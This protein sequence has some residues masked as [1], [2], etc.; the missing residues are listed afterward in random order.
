MNYI[1]NKSIFIILLFSVCSLFSQ[2]QNVIISG[3]TG[4]GG[5]TLTTND[6]TPKTTTSNSN[7]DYSIIVDTDGLWNGNIT[8]S[9]DGYTF[10][11]TQRSY[12]ET[13]G[14]T[15]QNYSAKLNNYSITGN[16]GTGGVT[17][18]WFEGRDQ[19]TVT[20]KSDGTYNVTV[21]HGWSGTIT[22][23][24]TGFTFN[25]VNKSYTNVTANQSNQNYIAFQIFIISGNTGTGNVL[26]S[27]TDGTQ[28]TTI[29][30][31]SGNYSISI[32]S[33]WNGT[34]VPSKDG[35]TFD[36]TSK[37][38]VEVG[39]DIDN[40][41]YA[42]TINKY[43]ITAVANPEVGGTID[44]LKPGGEYNH[45]ETVLITANSNTGFQ[46]VNWTLDGNEVSTDS[47]LSFVATGS[48]NYVANFELVKLNI[49]CSVN[50]SD[51]GTTN[52]CGTVLFNS[53]ITITAEANSDWIFTHWSEG[54]DT[55]STN[56]EYIFTAQSSR[57]LVA[58][59]SLISGIEKSD[60]SETIP[61]DYYLSNAYPNPFNPETTIKFGIPEES[62]V[63]FI[64]FDITGQIVETVLD[65]T[66]VQAGNYV[67]HFYANDLSSGIYLYLLNANST[68]SAKSFKKT[69]KVL[70]LK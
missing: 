23:S 6:S 66:I 34:V 53:E 60:N 18:S 25:P 52:G 65:N 39:S 31:N 41:D 3:N 12:V 32:P 67:N 70:L 57:N 63:S 46:F 36:P 1:S 50:P 55:V 9:K 62:N 47:V 16:A 21:P 13:A 44:N 45:D 58:N 24:K 37:G 43:L 59:F 35:Y 22:P 4:V 51:A 68:V 19:K 40:Q 30:D 61:Q 33:G 28:Q 64:V 8:P 38:Y 20:S 10:T 11:P 15:N 49:E 27:W 7:G 26:L 29:S 2:N 69:G 5:V 14:A 56:A 54:D 17:L 42:A 48:E